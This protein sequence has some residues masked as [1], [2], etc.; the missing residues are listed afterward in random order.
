MKNKT[1]IEFCCHTKMSKLQG[2]NFAREYIQEAMNRGYKAIAITDTNSTQAFLD[3]DEYLRDT[4]CFKAIYGIETNFKE[5]KD[6]KKI[7]KI[8]IYVKEQKGLKNLYTLV[9]NS[10]NNLINE[11]P[12][13]YKNE[14]DKYRE[15][16]L[17]A[18]VGSKSELAIK[19]DIET[20]NYYDFCRN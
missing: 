10:Y 19:Q 15:G 17:Y 16:L 8:Y 20:L 4:D 11:Q 1:R 18:A 12:I 2:I 13:I 7:Y 6:S 9:S 3:V 5:N 14:L